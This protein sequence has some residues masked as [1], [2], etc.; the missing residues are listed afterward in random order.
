MMD[1]AGLP[2]EHNSARM[3]AGA[4]SAPML[5]TAAAWQ[6]L[7]AELG[8]SAFAFASQTSALAGSAW[9]GPASA[10]MADAAATY[11]GWLN[12]AAVQAEQA[13]SQARLAAAAFEAA[14]AATVHPAII[15]V[16]RA[17]LL[18]LVAWNVLGQ[19]ARRSQPP[20]PSMSRC[21]PRM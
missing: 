10:A 2:P 3:F 14:R 15:S 18:R 1:F 12:A 17:R 8:S 20:R 19:S 21:G 7:A 11:V 4:G 6:G 9:Q 16:N 13:A 5:A